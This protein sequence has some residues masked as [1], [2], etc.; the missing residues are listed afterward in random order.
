MT[1][2]GMETRCHDIRFLNLN[3]N[4]YSFRRISNGVGGAVFS[5]LI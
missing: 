2:G 5:L 3:H 1:K 4:L